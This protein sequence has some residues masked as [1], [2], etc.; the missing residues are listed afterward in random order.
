MTLKAML[1]LGL[2]GALFALPAAAQPRE[3]VVIQRHSGHLPPV[4]PMPP[5]PPV[6]PVP[7]VMVALPPPAYGIPPHLVQKLGLSKELNQRIQDLTFAANDQ[8][9][10][11]EADLKRAQL[12]LDKLLRSA[13]ASEN[14]VM[15][16]VEAV[17]RAETA[18]RRNRIGLML[19]I[20]QQLGPD[21]WQKLEAE[22][23]E[24]R[25]EVHIRHFQGPD[26]APPPPR[27]EKK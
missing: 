11:L 25:R 16:Q 10:T 9:I 15:Q 14:A 4:P 8:L 22:L 3:D 24:V 17:G 20:K 12:E 26:E 1:S 6:P 18:V 5:M 27:G 21:N 2:T 19:Q 7:P 23:G 13:N